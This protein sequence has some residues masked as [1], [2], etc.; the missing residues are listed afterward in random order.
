M[1]NNVPGNAAAGQNPENKGDTCRDWREDRR[2]WRHEM[3]EQRHRWPFRGLF[4]GPTLVLLGV[5]FL[6]NQAGWITGDTLGQSLLIGLG[7][8]AIIN[9][10]VHYRHPGFRP[11]AFGKFIAGIV[12]ILV[13]ALL[14]AGVSQWWPVA[15]IV[16]GAAFLLRFFWRQP[17]VLP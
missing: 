4:W 7:V 17:S 14:L 3:R 11:G 16:A 2:H 8:I 10:V 1:E 12:L 15:L 5:L 9:G 6:C 13:G